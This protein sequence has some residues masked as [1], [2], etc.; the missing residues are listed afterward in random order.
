MLY[1]SESAV[2]RVVD[3][4]SVTSAIEA[5][6]VAFAEG[7]ARNFPVVRETLGYADAIFGFKS[8]FNFSGPTLGVKAGGLWPG[9]RAR[10]LANHQSTIVLFD[11]ETGGPRPLCAGRTSPRCGPLRQVRSRFDPLRAQAAIPAPHS[12]HAPSL[13]R[14]S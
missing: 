7:N 1:A 9:N 11:V 2:E 8:G 12:G 10:G 3:Q 14:R 4:T 13:P 5:M 6:F